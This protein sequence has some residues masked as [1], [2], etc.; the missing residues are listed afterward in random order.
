MKWKKNEW[1]NEQN[2]NEN[3]DKSKKE[4]NDWSNA[5]QGNNEMKK[6]IQWMKVMKGKKNW[7]IQKNEWMKFK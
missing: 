3:H 2:N 4:M 6:K 7:K 1:M 5:Q